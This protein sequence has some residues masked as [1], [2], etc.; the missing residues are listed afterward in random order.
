MRWSDDAHVQGNV[1][2]DYLN[3][4]SITQAAALNISRFRL[5]RMLNFQK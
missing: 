5:S 1:L 4:T 3:S 2:R